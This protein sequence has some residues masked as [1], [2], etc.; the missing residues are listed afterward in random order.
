MSE[1]KAVLT[2]SPKFDIFE[3]TPLPAVKRSAA[4]GAHI[5]RG[6][7]Y[8][9]GQLGVGQCFFVEANEE[10]GVTDTT[11]REQLEKLTR[12]V[13]G[14]STRLAKQHNVRLAVRTLLASEDP[15]QNPWGVAGTG[16]W[17]IEGAYNARPRAEKTVGSPA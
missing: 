6:S 5:Q 13:Q 11:S 4:F 16:V 7:I 12:K 10:N 2:K 1:N 14:S 9:V 3:S 15:E 8:P 17:R